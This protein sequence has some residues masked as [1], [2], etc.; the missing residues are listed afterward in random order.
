M[1]E[2]G[3]RLREAA[4]RHQFRFEG[5]KLTVTISAG[6][7]ERGAGSDEIAEQL[8]RRAD[9]QLYAAKAAGRNCVRG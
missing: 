1:L 4:A 3:E 6:A 5:H 2:L 9:E 7:A 8:Y